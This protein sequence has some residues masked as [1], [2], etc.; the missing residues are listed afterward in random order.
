MTDKNWRGNPEIFK[1]ARKG[2]QGD[3]WEAQGR[4]KFHC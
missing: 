2:F 3:A 4:E 1:V